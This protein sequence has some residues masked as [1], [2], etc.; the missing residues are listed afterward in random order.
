MRDFLANISLWDEVHIKNESI[1]GLM[2]RIAQR[3][4][5]LFGLKT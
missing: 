1:G 4:N 5:T 3:I 2:I